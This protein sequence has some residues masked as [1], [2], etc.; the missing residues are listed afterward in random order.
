[1]PPIMKID[2]FDS[3]G[4]T[5]PVFGCRTP[6]EVIDK[7]LTNI[8]LAE[9]VI[10]TNDKI[11]TLRNKYKRQNDPTFKD[12]TLMEL[13]AFLGILIMTGAR[14]DNHLTAE[15]MFSKSLGCPFYRSIMSECRFAFIQRAL[16]FD[17]IATREERVTHDKFAPIRNLW[18]QVIANCIANYEPSGHLTVDEQLLGFR[19]R[20]RFRMYIPNK[21]AKYGIKLV[22]ACDADTFYMCNAIP[23]LGKGTTNTSTPLG[24]YFTLELTR[25]FRKA[26]RIVTTDNW[27]TS[28]PLAKALRERGMHLV[29]TIR[30]KPYLPT[31]L[32]STPMEL[33]ESVATYNYK[34]KVTVL[35]QCVK[36]TKRIQILSTVHHNP[37]VIEDHKSHMHMFY[38]ATKGGVDTFDQICS[39]L[40]C[41]RKTRRWPV[42]VFYGIINLVMNN[43]F[44]IHQNLPDNT[45]YNRRQFSTELAIELA[46]DA[47]LSRLANKR[48]LPRDLTYLI[49][50]VFAVQEHEDESPDTRKRSEKRNRCP[51]CPSSSN[52]RTKLLCG[53][54][55]KPVCNSHVNYTC[56]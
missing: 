30:P 49:C 41:S 12:V 51:L 25:P 27:F 20:C 13:R 33:G 9:V 42:C 54:C 31:V 56:D 50:S 36:P 5:M 48:Y 43:S 47:A 21:P 32:L 53:K 15:E 14:K 55:H 19:G 29:G 26:G 18:D 22:M 44:F 17:S 3:A 28:L 2:Q 34:D 40:T 7:F 35:C 4:P 24:E 10:H 52:V 45:L 6:A 39:A 38:N 37:T 11:L 1:M 16:R 23:Y 8:M 46:R